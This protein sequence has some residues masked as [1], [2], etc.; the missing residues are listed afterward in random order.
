MTP[1]TLGER[2]SLQKGPEYLRQRDGCLLLLR[3][4]SEIV[5]PAR[6]IYIHKSIL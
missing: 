5:L 3:H 4:E 2:P 6:A 1:Q